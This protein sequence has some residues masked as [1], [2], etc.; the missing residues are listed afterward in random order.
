MPLLSDRVTHFEKAKQRGRAV[1]YRVLHLFR[2]V[3]MLEHGDVK[4]AWMEVRNL[5]AY[6]QN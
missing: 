5:G 2:T 6:V 1:R 3:E 4:E